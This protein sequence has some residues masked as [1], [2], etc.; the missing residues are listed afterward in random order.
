M[1]MKKANVLNKFFAL[2]FTGSQ[3]FYASRVSEPLE[4]GWWSTISHTAREKQV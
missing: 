2:I 3:S 4:G 1:E